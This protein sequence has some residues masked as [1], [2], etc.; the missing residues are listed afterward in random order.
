MTRLSTGLAA[1][2]NRQIP[3]YLRRVRSLFFHHLAVDPSRGGL[4]RPLPLLRLQAQP[5]R[6]PSL[7]HASKPPR[8][9]HPAVSLMLLSEVPAA[10]VGHS[11]SGTMLGL[12]ALDSRGPFDIWERLM[13]RLVSGL[14]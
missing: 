11:K 3:R 5:Q 1:S 6:D 2:V 12:R 7:R 4:L 9:V 13:G 8:S 10:W 14:A